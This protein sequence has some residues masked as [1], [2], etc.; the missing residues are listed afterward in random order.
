MQRT[1][2][3]NLDGTYDT[4]GTDFPAD[5]NNNIIDHYDSSDHSDYKEESGNESNLSE[6]EDAYGHE[7]SPKEIACGSPP[8]E[9]HCGSPPC[10]PF[11]PKSA[12]STVFGPTCDSI[13]LI[14]KDVE[15][16]DLE[17]GD[18]VYFFNMGA[19]TSAAASSFNGFNPP[20]TVYMIS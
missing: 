2:K 8:K 10:E 11:S 5:V 14:C 6:K 3:L 7:S 19:Y 9:S 1:K 17:I 4:S 16:P 18:I 12:K 20:E 13:D 15:L